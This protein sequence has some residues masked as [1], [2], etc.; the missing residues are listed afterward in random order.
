VR[1]FH[2]TNDSPL[3]I[4]TEVVSQTS[5]WRLT[6]LIALLIGVKQVHRQ[7]DAALPKYLMRAVGCDASFGTIFAINPFLVIIAIPFTTAIAA[8]SHPFTSIQIGSILVALAPFAFVAFAPSFAVAAAFVVVLSL[9]E[10]L[11]T[12]RLNEYAASIAPVGR[13][14]TY[15]A[16][17]HSPMFLGAC[18]LS[19]PSVFARAA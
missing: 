1:E 7:L 2:P 9:G 17:G 19:V 5:F 12:P 15:L 16:L 6:S 3:G 14:G 11:I 8:A 4:F 18:L 10:A 13:E